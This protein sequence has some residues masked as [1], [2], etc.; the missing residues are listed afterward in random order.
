[1]RNHLY[2]PQSAGSAKC[3]V[4]DATLCGED[5]DSPWHE[6]PYP[7]L[8]QPEITF[9][10]NHNGKLFCVVAWQMQSETSNLVPYA[11][12][13]QT[14]YN[15]QHG[16]KRAEKLDAP[17]FALVGTHMKSLTQLHIRQSHL[18]AAGLY[19]RE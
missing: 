6:L 13:W 2:W 11:A 10:L 19:G 8:V 3:R 14:T 5:E 9:R 4:F 18:I 16:W 12:A 1:M 7:A 15:G 17:D